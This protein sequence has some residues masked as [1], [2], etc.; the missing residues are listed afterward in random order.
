MHAKKALTVILT[1]LIFGIHLSADEHLAQRVANRQWGELSRE[2]SDNSWKKLRAYFE[3]SLSVRFVT[4]LTPKLTY[5]AKFKNYAE[6]GTLIYEK[7]NN[8][9]SSLK[10]TNQIKP[11][12]FIENFKMFRVFDEEITLGDA[13]LYFREGEFYL[14]QPYGQVLF[15]VGDWEFSILPSDPE[16]QVTLTQL[17]KEKSIRKSGKWG[18]LILNDKTFLSDWMFKL[19]PL[20]KKSPV[21]PLLTLYR[22]FFGIQIKQFQEFWYLP[23]KAD[24]NLV[25]FQKDNKSFFLYDFNATLTPDTRLRVSEKNHIILNYNAIRNP[26]LNLSKRDHVSQIYLNLFY[27]PES[28]FLSGTAILEFKNPSSF[29][30]LNLAE[31]LKI[32]A[33]LD[34]TLKGLSVI[35]KSQSYYF[36]GPRTSKLSFYYRGTI[37]PQVDHI[38]VFRK[39]TLDVETVEGDQFYFLSNAQTFYP[40]SDF[41]FF[42]SRLTISLPGK[43]TCLASGKLTGSVQSHRNTFKF[44]SSGIKG[45]AVAC[46]EFRII[47]EISSRIPIKVFSTAAGVRSKQFNVE[48]FSEPLQQ[49]QSQFDTIAK[50][51]NF[52]K[53]QDSLDF[54]IQRYGKLDLPEINLL[55]RKDIQ[56]GG[57][58][59]QGFIFFNYNPD[60]NLSQRITRKSPIILSQDPTN[61]LIHELCHQWW[62]GIVS[63]NSHEDVWITE[64]I[65]QF[66]LLHYLEKTLS[67]KKFS[68]ILKRM[69]RDIH[70]VNDVGPVGYGKRILDVQDDYE[71]YQTI[72][73][74]KS[75]FVLF[76]L[77]SILGEK[78][79]FERIRS[80]LKNNRYK[81][82][83]TIN[84]I[85]QFSNGNPLVLDFLIHWIN[86]RYIPEISVSIRKKQNLADITIRQKDRA[87]VFPL[88]LEIKTGGGTVFRS[89]IVKEKNQYVPLREDSI[90]H[91]IRILDAT[92][93]AKII[94]E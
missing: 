28:N 12:I 58:S 94:I 34:L 42:K 21:T 90:I 37:Q 26:K 93:L 32:M 38:D 69:K 5:K 87:V 6:I 50:Y 44:E 61:H 20:N 2:F 64:G 57:I 89:V 1:L 62:G 35:R 46:G 45:L 92:T 68:R 76:M 83:A 77:K 79:F 63:W 41:D 3:N 81:S 8:R 17:F 75:A 91:S 74:N 13:R 82:M 19:Q 25:I 29:R 52:K 36:L 60:H 24:D 53:L 59:N 78:D 40:I 84:F 4:Y 31:S 39:Q 51:F 55:L 22:E 73:Y 56:E 47:Q 23:F 54:L 48:A 65:T 66:S 18:I 71:A 72:I 80:L 15:F 88:D 43:F 33:S 11:L 49:F 85:K 7:K 86:R 14:S 10:I 67:K 27:N 70:N 30:V 9:Y 16:E